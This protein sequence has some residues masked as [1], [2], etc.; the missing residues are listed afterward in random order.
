ME[1][2]FRFFP[3]KRVDEA[4]VTGIVQSIVLKRGQPLQLKALWRSFALETVPAQLAD[5]EAVRPV[6][7]P[8]AIVCDPAMWGPFLILHDTWDIPVAVF[9]YMAACVLSGR[10]GPVP[11]FPL[12]RPR[13]WLQRLRVR[14]TR[15]VLSLFLADA[16]RAASK[17]RQTY[18][19][20]PLHTS[21]VDFSGQMPLYLVPSSPEFD[22]NRRDLPSSV[23]YVGPCFWTKPLNQPPPPWL[24][25]LPRDCPLIYVTEGTL[26]DQ[27]RVLRAAARGLANRRMNVV[28]TTGMHRDPVELGLDT[29]APNIRVERWV[30]FG[31]L[32]PRV[33]VVVTTGG[34]NTVLATLQAGVPL[35][36][37]PFDWDHPENAWHVEEAGAGLR[38]A[39]QDC[40]PERLCETVERVLN[41][42][43]F[44]ENAQRLAETL[45]RQGGPARAAE[46]LEGL[47]DGGSSMPATV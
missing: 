28:M 25:Q 11:G 47:V 21:V 26:H 19:L 3:L 34:P 32:L 33:D 5:L 15:A 30:P 12:P 18:G 43:S 29:M 2:G 45:A 9:Q 14:V 10:D 7:S 42:P 36:I 37:V 41:E 17:L 20:S 38:L 46:L 44:R 27:P 16:R 4:Q 40:A 24:A 1:E 35:V 39:P 6:W 31:D 8:D 22:Y 23:H 13:N